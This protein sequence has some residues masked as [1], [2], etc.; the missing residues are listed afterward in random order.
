[1]EA[2]TRV[3]VLTDKHTWRRAVRVFVMNQNKKFEER[4][5]P[6]TT[7]HRVPSKQR[8]SLGRKTAAEYITSDP[9]IIDALYR[10]SAYGKNF[11]ERGDLDLKLKKPTLIINDKDR[12]IVALRGLFQAVDLYMD[13]GLPYDV[14]KEQYEIH[15]SAISGKKINNQPTEIPYTAVDVLANIN[16]QKAQVRQKYEDDYGEPIPAIVE[17]DSA[18][19]DGLSVPGFNAQE[20]IDAKLAAQTKD[21]APAPANDKEALHTAYFDKFQKKVPNMKV[22]DLAWIKAKIEEKLAKKA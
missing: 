3:F 5:L 11:I 21:A 1:M 13:E 14:L 12:Q 6:F 17:N 9:V 22:N 8:T 4:L 20:Y 18:F 15:M 7:E 16:T 10:D 2:K 19:L